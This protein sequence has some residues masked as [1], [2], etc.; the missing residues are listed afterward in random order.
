VLIVP[1]LGTFFWLSVFGGTALHMEL[2]GE[3][4]LTQPIED[5]VAVSLHVL[6]RHMPLAEVSMMLATLVII[7]FFITSSDS[8]SL[9][10]D[11]VTSGGHP[12]PPRIQ[13]VFWAFSEGAVAATLLLVGGLRAIQNASIS[14]GFLMSML[15]I[16]ACISLIKS[17]HNEYH[18]LYGK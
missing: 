6:L 9:V 1:S 17:A 11:M 10:D 8:G 2:L 7:V 13:R 16:I 15:L 5:N 4:G 3:G 12:N 18:Q 14:L